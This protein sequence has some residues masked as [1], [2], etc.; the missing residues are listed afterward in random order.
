MVQVSE[1]CDLIGA[2]GTATARVIR[3]AEDAG[4]EEGAIDDQ[5]L[6]ALKEVEQ[7]YLGTIRALARGCGGIWSSDTSR[8][9][10]AR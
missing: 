7:A 9:K 8:G 4:L 1:V 5:L 10:S 6:A 3:P 2:E